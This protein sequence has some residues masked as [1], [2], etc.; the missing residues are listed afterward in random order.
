MANATG[1]PPRPG[2]RRTGLPDIIRTFLDRKIPAG[3]TWWHTLG[4]ALLALLIVQ[5]LTGTAMSLYYVPTP[6]HAYHSANYIVTQLPFGLLVRGI[7]KWN[8]SL[9]VILALAHLLRVFAMGAYKFP[10]EWNWVVGVAMLLVIMGFAF[11]GYLLP[12]DQKAYWATVVGT[13]IVSYVPWLGIAL[14]R[15]ARG[16]EQVGVLT[17]SRFF[18][19]H[20]FFLPG[21][22]TIL[23][24]FHIFMVVRQGIAAPPK[25]EFRS[26]P[27]ERYWEAYEQVK[28]RGQ[29]FWAHVFR[30]VIVITVVL[31]VAV[32]ITL[33]LGVPTEDI[34]DPTDVGYVPRPEWYFLPFYE[35]LWW[36]PGRWIPVGAIFIPATLILLALLLPFYDRSP[37]RALRLRPVA[38]GSVALLLLVGGAL[39]FRGAT[40]PKPPPPTVAR[41]GEAA[42]VAGA[43]SIVP[44]EAGALMFR[45]F[46]CLACHTVKG[47]G[48]QAGP[49]LTSVGDRRDADWMRRFIRNPQAVKATA[50][51]PPYA[52]LSDA[53]LDTL[54]AYLS[55]LK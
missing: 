23:A 12:W 22:L 26:I 46:G 33:I 2:D 28:A 44:A 53:Q 1:E 42:Q 16:G 10:R 35:L 25:G 3:V 18:A 36:F 21:L 15:L 34:A 41:A 4:S 29:P 55:T 14:E 11:T 50:A 5:A 52:G 39:T 48:G 27:K 19:L 40:A 13:K 6:E 30:D 51:M 38:A 47:Q 31:T 24:A 45:E 54:V 7:H 49:D 43:R 9:I 17:L 32:A 8:S 37:A 20:V